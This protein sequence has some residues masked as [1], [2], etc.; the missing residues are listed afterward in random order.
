VQVAP[1]AH[2]AE[3]KAAAGSTPAGVCGGGRVLE[4]IR[5]PGG[6]WHPHRRPPPGSVTVQALTS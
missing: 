2:P 6:R 4:D 3:D 5:F 1:K